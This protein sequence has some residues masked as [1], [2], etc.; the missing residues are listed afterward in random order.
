MS[1]LLWI[2]IL[3]AA[4]WLGARHRKPGVALL[5]GALAGLL[6]ARLVQRVAA[7]GWLAALLAGLLGL[8]LVGG[9]GW[10]RFTHHRSRARR[11]GRAV[12]RKD[13]LA[14]TFDV[15][16]YGSSAAMRRKATRVRPTLRE[17]SRWERWRLPV[18]EVAV[19]LCRAG[20][21]RVWVSVE[22]VVLAF[23]I[24]RYGKSGWLGCYVL[25][26]PGAVV[27][28]STKPDLYHA[29]RE[30]RAKRGPVSVFNPTGVG[31]IASTVGFNPVAGA[32]DPVGAGHRAE[33]MLACGGGSG[34]REH[35]V[36]Q[37]R[38][39]L[40]GLLHAAALGGLGMAAISAWVADPDNA[41]EEVVRLLDSSD[42]STGAYATAAAA[43]FGT[44]T[45][46]RSSITASMRPA[47]TWL[48]NPHARAC[49][50]TTARGEFNVAELLRTRGTVYILGAEDGSTASLVA[51]F[52]GYIARE[53]RRIADLQPEGRLDPTL[54]L[55]LDEAAIICPIPL[56]RWSADMGGRGIQ[57]V[58]CFQS[59]AQVI[60]RWGTTGG[61]CLINNAG[62]IMLY[63]GCKD[64]A[65]L[66]FWSSLFGERDE[67]ILTRDR[68]GEVTSRS[69]R[70]VPVF[71]P[72][73]LAS[74]PTFRVVVWRSSMLPVLGKVDKFWTR[75][76]Y[77]DLQ[78][79]IARAEREVVATA[80]DTTTG[81]SGRPNPVRAGLA[82]A[83]RAR[84]GRLVGATRRRGRGAL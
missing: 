74:L 21:M 83:R 59:R 71:T 44:N 72:A 40:A 12:R 7:A 64:Q 34:E 67:Q 39:V 6:V 69:V 16:R 49:T 56:D 37:A 4:A 25:D 9:V 70:R 51:A 31:G 66:A 58:A 75:P 47:F 54:R 78:A 2:V 52:T 60:G 30:L 73:Q 8:C 33:D 46:T 5:F 13:G 48:P 43:F 45:R 62:G 61:A 77:R 82:A 57:I 1:E 11:W 53:A 3:S 63:G 26:G 76:E 65:D 17:L 22:D 35:W 68:H 32:G 10:Y 28:T 23:G 79:A 42:D 29:T 84:A 24:P 55:A 36:S 27:T 81:A 15:L 19:P 14:S 50:D 41:A 20:L 18:T 38:D 80:T